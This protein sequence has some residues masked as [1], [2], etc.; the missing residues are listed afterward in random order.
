MIRL[1]IDIGGTFTDF[2]MAGDG[3]SGL[4]V[5]KRLTT[6]DDPSRAVLE[7]AEALLA[8]HGLGMREVAEIVHGTTL[9]TNAVI[10]RR[11]AVTGMLVTRGFVDAL[12]MGLEQRYDLFD[13]RLR[14]APPVVG[15]RCR[16][17][18]DER[19]AHDGT[20][21]TAIDLAATTDAI[22]ALIDAHGIEALAVCFLNAYVN[23]VHEQAV[24]DL[25]ARAFPSL[26]VTTSADVAPQIREFERWTTA[27]VN[28]YCQPRFDRYLAALEDGLA[29]RG[30]AGR[31][32]M[33]SSSG[34]AVTP[35]TARRYPVRMLESGPA[36]GV[37]MSAEHG[38]RLGIADLLA[39][40]LG[41]TT[42]KGA[43]VRDGRPVRRYAME[44]A[45][46]HGHK[47]GSGLSLRLPVVDMTEIGSGGGSVAHVDE[48]LLLRVGPR[49]TGA[50]PGPACYGRGGTLAT[51]T[52]ANLML[53]YLDP[54]F[55]LGGAMALD[56]SRARA[57]IADAIGGPLRLGDMRAAWGIHEI[58]NE[59]IARAFRMH[60]V[61]R[62]FDCR[63]ATIVAF[64][65]GGPI[66]ATGVARKLGALRVVLPVGAGVMSALGL[67]ASPLAFEVARSRD[68]PLDA[69]GAAQFAQLMDEVAGEAA[70]FLTA[71]GLAA[72]D[73]VVDRRV[74]LRHRG[75]G[76]EL[77][78][79]LPPG[80]AAADSF[81]RLPGLFAGRYRAMFGVD[82]L[83]EPLELVTLKAEARGPVP[84]LPRA[85]PDAG[86]AGSS[87]K[88]ERL[89]YVPER[90]RFESVP[91]HDR[92]R[93][94]AGD[95]VPG[96]AL[97][98]ERESTCLLRDGDVA[99]VDAELNLVVD[100]GR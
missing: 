24:R 49:S 87:F 13:L 53:G 58:V 15:R 57:A 63:R 50:M 88:G 9:V 90:A 3:V 60:A 94:R 56:R 93:L 16:A 43:I 33:M 7:G 74:D 65:G 78:I 6:P 99:T 11:G 66:H 72:C 62:S 25:A 34:G 100:I 19:V 44:V 98:E 31:F 96:P 32:L 1:G 95:R 18:I 85:E 77:E 8:R 84:D 14:F 42:A 82:A 69:L 35:Q 5:H 68:V 46:V 45:R 22:A 97:I 26:H 79:A 37:L 48:R 4:A 39:F 59:D 76:H 21:V 73:M 54:G 71:A 47:R 52:D 80:E 81:A 86:A 30:F 41:G 61:E 38:R 70:A 55:F 67:L 10:E 91:V 20:V 29:A 17:E 75:Q 27:T 12:E 40:D 36:A 2:V 23:P 83:G 64:G 51:L 28:A 89:A 92:Y